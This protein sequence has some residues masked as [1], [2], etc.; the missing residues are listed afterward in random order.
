VEVK[1]LYM[2]RDGIMRETIYDDDAPDRIVVHTRQ[3]LDE[4]LDGIARDRETMRHGT[5]K[6][7]ATLPAF[8]VEDLI[9]RGIYHDPDAFDAWL[10]SS[11]C[12]PWR[13]WQGR[14]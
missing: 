14:I 7:L 6:K 2:V 5:N 10:N 11:E 13:V 8:V 12:D 4:I 9:H 3:E 1:R